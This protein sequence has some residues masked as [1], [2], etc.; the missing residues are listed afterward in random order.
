MK[1]EKKQRDVSQFVDCRTCQYY[2]T[3]R[4]RCHAVVQCVLANQYKGKD[5]IQLWSVPKL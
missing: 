2:Q 1:E 3:M 5:F 4:G